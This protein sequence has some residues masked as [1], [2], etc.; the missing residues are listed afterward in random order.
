MGSSGR[1]CSGILSMQYVGLIDCNNFFVSC[2]R[3][4]RPDLRTKPVVVLSSNDGCIVARSREV[5]EAGIPMGIPYF[6]VKKEL[7]DLQTVIFSSNFPLY[8]DIS[9]RVMHM[10]EKEVGSIEQYSVD[11]AFF[12]ID[13]CMNI[14]KEMARIRTSIECSVGVPI[15]VGVARTKTIAKY[16]SEIAK[17][18]VGVCFLE[19]RKWQEMTKEVSVHEIW[20]I[21]RQ[22]SQ[23]MREKG[24]HT[25]A[26]LL[27]TDRSRIDTLFGIEGLRKLDA[28]SEK[29]IN[30]SRAD[31]G[32]KS[33]MSTRSFSKTTHVR[34]DVE[35][36]LAYH[37]AHAAASLRKK[38]LMARYVH[39]LAHASRHGDWLLKQSTDEVI[40][41]E[42]T[43]DTRTLLKEALCLFRGFYNPEVPYKKAG[44]VLGG[45]IDVR[46]MQGQ[47]FDQK[48][49]A[50]QSSNKLM[51]TLDTIND[52]YGK[53]TVTIGRVQSKDGW[54]TSRKHISPAYTTNWSQLATVKA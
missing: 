49:D 30:S 18:S 8:R 39:V 29:Q 15:S 37:V 44:V 13:A 14:E 25:V 26:D 40:L 1:K 38:G 32:Q 4:F 46:Y 23:K 21:G 35:D 20:G 47:L 34:T 43:D 5:K 6:K 17:K 22:T 9:T 33:I 24:I 10:L 28:L 54:K 41:V 7:T 2:E 11:E 48:L 45:L 53:E 16:A 3:L 50:K 19:G 52:R 42:P 36:A 31:A 12:T 51:D 27:A